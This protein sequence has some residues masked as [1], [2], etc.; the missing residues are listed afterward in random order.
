MELFTKHLNEAQALLNLVAT[1]EKFLSSA[2]EAGRA[3]VDCLRS[4][5]KIMSCGNGGSMCDAMHF[6]EELTG[7]YREDRGPIAAMALSDVSHMSCVAN[8]Y[9]F[10]HVFERGVQAFGKSGDVLLAIS[11]SG[12]SSNILHA[13]RAAR[14]QGLIVVALTGK[15]G[16][17]LAEL[18]NIE[19]RVPWMGYADRIQE[20]HIKVI[21]A[22]MDFIEQHL[23][24]A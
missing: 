20:I 12:N 1:D 23:L 18:A 7:R 22:W 3:M 11:T 2:H 19:V 13:A 17:Q 9:G 6:A 4:G 21:H 14:E 8:D 16:G 10:D 15:N 5:G 24:E